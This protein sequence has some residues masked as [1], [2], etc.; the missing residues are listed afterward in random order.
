MKLL[1]LLTILLTTCLTN[2]SYAEDPPPDQ[3]YFKVTDTSTVI[4][5]NAA[6][7]NKEMVGQFPL[8]AV[9]SAINK[10]AFGCYSF[11]NDRGVVTI[12]WWNGEKDDY[13]MDKFTPEKPKPEITL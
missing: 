8:Q 3:L 11:D 6:C 7:L 2:I 12:Q 5:T 10:V 13:P 1:Q 4:A 9:F